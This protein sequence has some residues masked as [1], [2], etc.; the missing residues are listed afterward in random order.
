M[1][2]QVNYIS[3]NIR[4]MMIWKSC[5]I[6]VNDSR[7]PKANWEWGCWGKAPPR[8]ATCRILERG[9]AGHHAWAAISARGNPSRYTLVVNYVATIMLI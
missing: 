2:K 9:L 7:V 8:T 6:L 4:V 5:R 1:L 3:Y